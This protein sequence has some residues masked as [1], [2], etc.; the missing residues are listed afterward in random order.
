MLLAC[1]SV[2]GGS[3]TTVVAAGL[4]LVLARRRPDGVL[5]TDLAGDLP[6]VFGL[7]PD[8]LSGVSDWIAAGADVPPDARRRLEVDV[9]RGVRL[10]PRGSLRGE[11]QATKAD[12]DRLLR[13]LRDGTPAGVEGGPTVV[14][15]AGRIEPA[16]LAE[17]VVAGATHSLLVVRPCYLALRRAVAAP[18]RP[19]GVVLVDEP[20]RALSPGDVEDALGVPVTAV[21]PQRP[22]I[23][24]A[25]D[26]GLLGDRVPRVLASAL[27]R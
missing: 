19:T 22:E 6:A 11:L 5:L 7:P 25:V 8:T 27:R 3:G 24:R 17:A 13:S 12:A 9:D 14:V 1:W 20:G 16:S 10:L 4:A 21:V 15:D 2:K 18:L 26:A 23:A